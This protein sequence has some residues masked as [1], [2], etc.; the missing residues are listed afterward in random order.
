MDLFEATGIA[1]QPSRELWEAT[2]LFNATQD[3]GVYSETIWN[4][5]DEY[6]NSLAVDV[7]GALAH[8]LQKLS[9]V[10]SAWLRVAR[11]QPQ[12]A[13]AALNIAHVRRLLGDVEGTEQ[14]FRI[15]KAS[16]RPRDRGL[17]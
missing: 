6:P 2:A 9:L 13:F 15:A 4:L 8:D 11:L 10:E 7:L 1:T 17:L 3:T 12:S 5:A 16:R 14:A